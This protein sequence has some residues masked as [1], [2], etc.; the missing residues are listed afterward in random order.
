[1]QFQIPAGS[2]RLG[3][4]DFA[5]WVPG[6]LRAPTLSS[7][8]RPGPSSGACRPDRAPAAPTPTPGSLSLRSRGGGRRWDRVRPAGPGAVLAG[9]A[10]SRS[11]TASPP[12]P[13]Q[14]SAHRAA[15]PGHAGH[16]GGLRGPA[17]QPGR[18]SR[19][20]RPAPI[21]APGP[22]AQ[23]ANWLGRSRRSVV[24]LP[25]PRSPGVCSSRQGAGV[26][27]PGRS[28][29]PQ[30]ARKSA[31]VSCSFPGS[32]AAA[33]S[34]GPPVQTLSFPRSPALGSRG[35]EDSGPR[36]VRAPGA[37][38][39]RA[40]RTPGEKGQQLS[41][42][43]QPAPRLRPPGWVSARSSGTGV[44]PKARAPQPCPSLPRTR[45]RRQ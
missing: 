14:L 13:P 6:S 26:R 42:K 25:R 7:P 24:L 34:L 30:G 44:A 16:R 45:I 11:G 43:S 28:S 12:W 19:R 20:R 8:G 10:P 41:P 37:S 31:R 27:A 15:E 3:G 32:E 36:R 4:L 1:M 18:C 29:G 35:S 5:V 2:S 39:H 33:W 40:S 9:A 21:A 22:W 23:R 38:A 17:T